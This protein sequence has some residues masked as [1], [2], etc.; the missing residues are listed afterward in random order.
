MDEGRG[1]G[2]QR[3]RRA[4]WWAAAR[5]RKEGGLPALREP[6]EA[7]AREREGQDEACSPP[8]YTSHNAA[9]LPAC[10]ASSLRCL[11]D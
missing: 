4:Q 5:P 3:L 9:W 6:A 2:G 11:T 10:L 1:G 8:P 7:A